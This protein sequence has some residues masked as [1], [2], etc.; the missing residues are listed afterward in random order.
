M[1]ASTSRAPPKQVA[2]PPGTSPRSGSGAATAIV[3][4]AGGD[5]ERCGGGGGGSA[6]HS[7]D[8]AWTESATVALIDAWGERYLQLNRGNL[9]QKHWREVADEVNRRVTMDDG[10]TTSN[11]GKT[12]VQC[13]NRLDTLKK[14]YKIEKARFMSE[15]SPS[16]WA[17][18]VRLDELVG[19]SKKGK[20]KVQ[21]GSGNGNG[22]GNG[23]G[24]PPA[25]SLLPPAFLPR[26]QAQIHRLDDSKV[27]QQHQQ[28]PPPQQGTSNS[29]SS[30][31]SAGMSDSCENHHHHHNQQQQHHH[32]GN[33]MNNGSTVDGKPSRKRKLEGPFKD[34]ARAIIKFGE[35]YERIESAKQQQLMD[36]ERQRMEFIKELELQRMQLFMQTQVELAKMKHAKHGNTGYHRSLHFY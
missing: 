28:P 16:K 8:D 34:L 11:C 27:Q 12:D 29:S 26:Q 21:G 13:K 1:P 5:G 6:G 24:L 14:K 10:K 18:F 22:N 30:K 31:E 15:G 20:K 3:T 4:A 33:A 32:H 17:F 35:V 36:L 19:P 7:R 23:S 2:A 25:A 9:K